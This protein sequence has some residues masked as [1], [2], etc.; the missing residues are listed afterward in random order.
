LR[1]HGTAGSLRRQLGL[2]IFVVL[3]LLGILL[4][5]GASL[6]FE[7]V[8][9]EVAQARVA[10]DSER[11]LAAI[12]NGP[13]GVFLDPARLD[14]AYNRPLSGQY[15]VIRFG[16]VHWRSRSLWDSELPVAS[17]GD[18]EF[19]HMPGPGSQRLLLVSR[20]FQRFGHVFTITVAN[21]YGPLFNVFRQAWLLATA[22]WVLALLATMLGLNYWSGRALYPLA[23]AKIQLAEIQEGERKSLDESV[24]VELLPMIRQVNALLGET[25]HALS[26]SR[27]ALGNLGH[28]LKTPLAVL[29]SLIEREEVRRLPELHQSLRTQLDQLEQRITRELSQTHA[30]TAG[31]IGEPFVPRRDLP[32]IVDALQRAHGRDLVVELIFEDEQVLAVERVDMLEV[33]GNLLDNAWKWALSRVRVS[34]EGTAQKWLIRVEDDG[35]GIADPQ[36]RQQALERG[37]RLDE[38]VAGQGLGLAIVA[39][40]VAACRGFLV[41]EHSALGGLAVRVELPRQRGLANKIADR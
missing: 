4:G 5:S 29:S 20:E 3:S 13:E 6:L 12:R 14:P 23:R 27:N 35:P 19:I 9:R 36:Q 22:L 38:S 2:A 8:Q 17:T 30:G 18:G 40:I 16:D 32:A 26:R 10:A 37:Y 33:M 39:D 24:P 31:S 21:D 11:L 34:V 41:L 25:R 7:Q 28:A 15:F 1:G